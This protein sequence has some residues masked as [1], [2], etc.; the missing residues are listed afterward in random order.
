MTGLQTCGGFARIGAGDADVISRA[1]TLRPAATIRNRALMTNPTQ[2]S[3]LAARKQ[4][5]REGL[6]GSGRDE[7][8][9]NGDLELV[10]RVQAGDASAFGELVDRHQRSVYGIVSR[11]VHSRDEVDDLV[12]DIF[13]SAY[14]AMGRFR[15]EAKFSTWLHSIA[16]NM[17]LKR[18]KRLKRQGAVSMDD[19]EQG[20]SSVISAGSDAEP[21]EIVE[22]AQQSALMRR[23]IDGLPDKQRVVVI[24][25]YF[26]QLSCEEIAAVLK[27]SVGT[28][29]SRLHYACR[30]LKNELSLLEQGQ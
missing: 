28:V 17:T 24:M 19:P 8:E 12:Q 23:A 5:L 18:L 22:R 29:W 10:R 21:D 13:V 26:E 1:G 25:H 6:A 7:P 15:C 16:V 4:A 3:D 30:K 14:E 27:C 11:M 9:T 20:L 2:S